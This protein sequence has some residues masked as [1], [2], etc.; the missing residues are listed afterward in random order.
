[1]I[2]CTDENIYY[3]KKRRG[4]AKRRFILIIIVALVTVFIVYQQNA[5]FSLLVKICKDRSMAV[6]TFSVNKAV[7]LTLSEE[8]NYY[9]LIAVDKNSDGDIV[10][11]SANALKINKITR[12]IA[13][14]TNEIMSDKLKEGINV[15]IL[16]FTGITFFSGI[17]R[18]VNY[19]Y[20]SVS[21][22]N[23]D[24]GGEFKS[25]GINQTLHSVY[26]FIKA[27]V[28]VE[29][30]TASEDI[31]LVSKVLLSEAVLVGKVPEIYL[32]GGL[33]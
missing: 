28:N 6:S 26:A 32:N 16:A 11:M 13:E 21:D 22:V 5:V 33:L 12:E 1:M 30:L 4:K 19:K 2:Y 29:F 20:I 27:K 23:C 24:I 17:G 25:V 10:L 18:E 7:T 15:P 9:D 31:E 8:L 14:K 3:K